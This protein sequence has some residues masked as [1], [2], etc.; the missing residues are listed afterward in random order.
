MPHDRVCAGGEGYRVYIIGVLNIPDNSRYSAVFIICHGLGVKRARLC[1]I[2][3]V[4]SR[5]GHIVFL[6]YISAD[7]ESRQIS[8]GIEKAERKTAALNL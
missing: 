6:K 3:A 1:R 8:S 5:V 7:S 2:I 4:G